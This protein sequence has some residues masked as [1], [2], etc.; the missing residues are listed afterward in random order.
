MQN[1]KLWF[2]AKNYGWGWYPVSWEGWLVTLVYIL[3]IIAIALRAVEITEN[4]ED[5]GT[6]FL[7]NYIPPL[8]L[9]SIPMIWICYKTGE[10]PEWRWGEKGKK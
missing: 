7:C 9:L 10:K 2:K 3:G 8:I 4:G 5:T 1:K 6:Q